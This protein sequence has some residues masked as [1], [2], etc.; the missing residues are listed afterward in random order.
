ME[1]PPPQRVSYSGPLGPGAG[2][3][4]TGKKYDD[5]S[6]VPSRADLATLSGLVACRTLPSEDSRLETVKQVNESSQLSEET[7]RKQDQKRGMQN[8]ASSR[9][10]ETGRATKGLVLVSF[11][12]TL[13][14]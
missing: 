11:L 1:H 14:T 7:M 3:A 12:R 2:W 5:V 4:V 8:L 6:V 9:H 13:S 10:I